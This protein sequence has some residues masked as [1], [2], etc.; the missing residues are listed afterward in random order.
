VARRLAELD[1]ERP[2]DLA[3][4]PL[5]RATLLGLEDGLHDLLFNLH[6]IVSDGW[7]IRVVTRELSAFYL[8]AAAGALPRLD[9]LEVQYPD[10]AAWQRRWLAGAEL[11]RQIDYWRAQ[12]AGVEHGTELPTDRP[13]PAVRTHRGAQAELSLSS[14]LSNRVRALSRGQGMTLFVTLLA[15]F[16]VVLARWSGEE[17]VVVGAPIAGRTR[18]EVEGLIGIFLNSLV[19]RTE[20]ADGLSFAEA[21]GRMRATLREAQAHQDVPFEKLLEE[22]EP[23]RDLSRTPFFQVFFNQFDLPTEAEEAGELAIEPIPGLDFPAKFDLT[24]YSG[25]VEE[26]LRFRAVYNT[27]LFD[28]ATIR[29]LLDQYRAVLEAVTAD[30]E[31][32]IWEIPLAEPSA[33]LP[34]PARELD[35][36][37]HGPVHAWVA[38]RARETPEKVAVVDA[39]GQ[40][41]YGKLAERMHR[42]AR[43]LCELGVEKG[44]RVA[45][46]AHRSA[47]LSWAVLGALEAGGAFVSLDPAYPA[48]YLASILRRAE[49]KVFLEL[50]AAGPL[51]AEL[52]AALADTER[53]RLPRWPEAR[54]FLDD[55]PAEAPGVDI[56]PDDIAY[57]AFTSGSTGEPKGVMGR[58][59]PLTHF[60]PWQAAT[61]GLGA[62]DRTSL[63]SGLAHDPLQRDLFT[64]LC[65]GGTLVVPDPRRAFEAGYLAS[66]LAEERLTLVHLTPAM[67]RLVAERP[68]DR[69]V[70]AVLRRALFV[71][72]VLTRRDVLRL[73]ELAPEVRVV[74]LYGSTETQRA[75]GYCEIGDELLGRGL[76]V[77]PLGRGMEDVQLLVVNRAGRPAA[78]G[79]VGEIVVR[80]P[81]LSAGYLG[82]PELTAERFRDQTYRTGDLG[83]YLTTGEVVFAGRADRQVKIRGFRVELGEIESHLGG[84]PG[85]RQAV[86][87]VVGQ[88]L[89]AYVVGE[90]LD[91][92]ALRAHLRER[93]PV[94]MVPAA[95]VELDRLPLTPNGKVDRRAL[96][97]PEFRAE[98]AEPPKN[99][100]EKRLAAVWAEVLELEEVGVEDN[101]FDL[102]GHSLLL[103]RLHRRL[104]EAL[105]REVP[106]VTLF[107]HPNVRSLAQHLE[108]GADDDLDEAKKRARQQIRAT[109]KRRKRPPKIDI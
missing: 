82:D 9:E 2:F 92:E 36:A 49:P 99:D 67:G 8:A 62:D 4:G 17:E 69:E 28:E 48:P 104:E 77:M 89:V 90:G 80:S 40:W 25:E 47:E 103:V 95:F 65:L 6:H 100:L 61:F 76:E 10:Y 56:G 54:D 52:E 97:K 85:V 50:E 83:R 78:L 87:A 96:P 58:H 64:S 70:R 11:E 53:L 13:R 38:E 51:P 3:S 34:D 102:G 21:L 30:V 45:I 18:P 79:E 66:W 93:L 27:D 74:N 107:Q 43:R 29:A 81:H 39:H 19:L 86:T 46:W 108:G 5:L 88:R 72:D 32:P 106:L 7:S 26:G 60:L 73:Q 33:L 57:L 20:L 59:G 105:E 84:A 91:F 35:A 15:A 98:T 71:G 41:T 22:L 75:V 23:E 16:E 94:H 31:V 109:R 63:L 14:E 55:E 44:D 24:I 68:G 12:L 42:L 101:F 37:W 1:A